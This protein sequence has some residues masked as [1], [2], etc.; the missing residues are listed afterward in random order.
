MIR[1]IVVSSLRQATIG[2]LALLVGFVM[3]EPAI[4]HAAVTSVTDVF[5]VSQV[6]DAEVGF[7]T[8]ASNVTM[9]PSIGGI[10]GGT[11]NG[12][13]S[14]SV[15]TN[16]LAGYHMTLQAS[17]SLGMQN[18]SSTTNYIPAYTTTT[19]GVPDYAFNTAANGFAYTV[20]AST[21][22]DV[23]QLFRTASPGSGPCNNAGLNTSSSACWL[24]ATSTAVTII[25]RTTPTAVSGA[26][27][28]LSFEA[29]LVANSMLPNGTYVATTTL[30]AITN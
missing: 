10:T 13:T 25:N 19:N 30:T 20:T 28:T 3:I 4:S 21:T 17:N 6:V 24:G 11:S 29:N 12:V 16:D 14:V 8:L 22:S 26:T 15:R 7:A 1:N 23:A 9:S 5:T 2:T 18:V 27:T